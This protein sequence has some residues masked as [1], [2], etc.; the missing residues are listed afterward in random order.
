MRTYRM[1][2]GIIRLV[3][4]IGTV[5]MNS[6]II[7]LAFFFWTMQLKDIP[8]EDLYENEYKYVEFIERVYNGNNKILLFSLEILGKDE[9]IETASFKEGSNYFGFAIV[10]TDVLDKYPLTDN[11]QLKTR[12]LFN[13]LFTVEGILYC[14]PLH[15]YKSNALIWAGGFCDTTLLRNGF[16]SYT[17]DKQSWIKDITN[18]ATLARFCF[19]SPGPV[20]DFQTCYESVKKHIDLCALLGFAFGVPLVLNIIDLIMFS[21]SAAASNH[22]KHFK[23]IEDVN[24][25]LNVIFLTVF[26]MEIA[27]R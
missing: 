19:P 2:H 18:N 6:N 7:F 4:R 15:L 20:T 26:C 3:L 14:S 12:D 21:V 11:F 16:L 10:T 24:Q 9:I 5:L 1:P 17:K 25:V 23:S 8:R 22:E 27:E 13:Q